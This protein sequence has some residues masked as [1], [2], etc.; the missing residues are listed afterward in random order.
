MIPAIVAEHGAEL[1]AVLLVREQ[2]CS[3]GP[4]ISTHPDE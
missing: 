3:C 4:V 2:T 1:G